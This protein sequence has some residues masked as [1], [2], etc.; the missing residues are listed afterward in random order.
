MFSIFSTALSRFFLLMLFQISR[1]LVEDVQSALRS[2]APLLFAQTSGI[3]LFLPL[4]F[5]SQL[6]SL[7]VILCS[8]SLFLHFRLVGI[9]CSNDLIGVWVASK[10]F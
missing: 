3:S 10:V 7:S 1:N 8:E 9:I 4:V 6:A 5:H 2:S